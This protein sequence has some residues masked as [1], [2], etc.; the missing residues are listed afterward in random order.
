MIHLRANID[1]VKR[2]YEQSCMPFNEVKEL[3]P[4]IQ[5]E[6][7]RGFIVIPILRMLKGKIKNL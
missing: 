5:A 1:A 7:V 6:M 2:Q 4:K 3:L